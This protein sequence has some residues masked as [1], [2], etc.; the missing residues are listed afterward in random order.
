[1]PP[2][3]PRIGGNP[4]SCCWLSL[5]HLQWVGAVALDH[6]RPGVL[7]P[8][9]GMGPSLTPLTRLLPYIKAS[10][11]GPLSYHLKTHDAPAAEFSPICGPW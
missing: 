4:G 11:Y 2:V 6:G 8:V 9:L 7:P 10:G 5:P 1:M 3:Q